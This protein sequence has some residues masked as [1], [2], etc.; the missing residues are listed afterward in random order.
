MQTDAQ[1][2]GGE[3][4]N[5]QGKW[6]GFKSSLMLQQRNELMR[7]VCVYLCLCRRRQRRA[8]RPGG[9]CGRR[10]RRWRRRRG[11]GERW[12]F[13]LVPAVDKPPHNIGHHRSDPILKQ[14][15]TRLAGW[16]AGWLA[17]VFVVEYGGCC[18]FIFF[19]HL[20]KYWT[21]RPQKTQAGVV[22]YKSNSGRCGV[23]SSVAIFRARRSSRRRLVFIHIYFWQPVFLVITA[24]HIKRTLF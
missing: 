8:T 22:S 1:T 16:Q 15:A 17:C 9:K 2:D 19:F 14:T 4:I 11:S 18:C 10:R 24:T 12:G 3:R 23:V 20:K 21:H 13:P 6:N 5:N 7:C